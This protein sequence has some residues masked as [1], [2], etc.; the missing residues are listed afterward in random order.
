MNLTIFRI[1]SKR[2][3]CFNSKFLQCDMI[4]LRIFIALKDKNIHKAAHINIYLE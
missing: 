2:E 1:L 3:R 4:K